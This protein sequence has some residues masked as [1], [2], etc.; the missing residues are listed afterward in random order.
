MEDALYINDIVDNL[1]ALGFDFRLLDCSPASR[2]GY[3]SGS[4]DAGLSGT[5]LHALD[6]V[7]SVL[8][9]GKM[10]A[11]RWMLGAPGLLGQWL[12]VRGGT[13]VVDMSVADYSAISM[14]II[15]PDHRWHRYAADC[16]FTLLAQDGSNLS[17]QACSRSGR[18]C[19][20]PA[21][22]PP[23]K[24]TSYWSELSSSSASIYQDASGHATVWEILWESATV[25]YLG[26][27]MAANE[28]WRE[29]WRRAL[30]NWTYTST[31]TTTTI[32]T[33]TTLTLTSFL[34]RLAGTS[35]GRQ[36]RLQLNVNG[37]W[38]TACVQLS[39]GVLFNFVQAVC[40]Q[41]GFSGGLPLLRTTF[42]ERTDHY[43]QWT[44]EGCLGCAVATFEQSWA[45]LSDGPCN[46]VDLSCGLPSSGHTVTAAPTPSSTGTAG[47]P[48]TT[49]AR[50]STTN[51]ARHNPSSTGTAGRP[52][53][54]KARVTTTT[55]ARHNSPSS[56]PARTTRRSRV[57]R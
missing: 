45:V 29:V 55:K 8:V 40:S 12:L 27:T 46:A 51:T 35:T 18:F 5:N 13:L 23:S 41:L 2:S 53:T 4:C 16:E 37:T 30:S 39:M 34:L 22:L 52:T 28:Q 36:G 15:S 44:G 26:N 17:V 38:G 32:T 56:T 7:Q 50:V 54:T 1:T 20:G 33:T 9:P 3:D 14:T 43:W 11:A 42:V 19:S 47:R 25:L 6:D 48:T 24:A 49:E 21:S 10:V 57:M 31:T